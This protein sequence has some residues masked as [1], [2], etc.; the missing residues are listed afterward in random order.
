VCCSIAAVAWVFPVALVL[1]MV[2]LRLGSIS[3]PMEEY[4]STA[5]LTRSVKLDALFASKIPVLA[6]IFDRYV[7]VSVPMNNSKCK[8]FDAA[9]LGV[10]GTKLREDEWFE[11]TG[12]G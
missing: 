7:K 3:W 8:E 10:M 12:R 2:P 4:R 11:E 6:S 5:D 9:G 1:E